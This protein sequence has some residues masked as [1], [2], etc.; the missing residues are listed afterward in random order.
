MR[1][2][3]KLVVTRATTVAADHL[4]WEDDEYQPVELMSPGGAIR[5]VLAGESRDLRN[6]SRSALAATEAQPGQ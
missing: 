6:V 2:D 4:V 3:T 5:L 1:Q